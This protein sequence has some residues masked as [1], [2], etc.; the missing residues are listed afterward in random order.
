MKLGFRTNNT[1]TMNLAEGQCTSIR[2]INNE[3]G[4]TETVFVQL[5]T[6]TH[7]VNT[8]ACLQPLA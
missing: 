1:R 8:D 2:V 3:S 4:F 7:C 6:E 5:P